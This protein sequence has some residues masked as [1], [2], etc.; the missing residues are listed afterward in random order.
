LVFNF[1]FQS[2]FCVCCFIRFDPYYFF[3][4]FFFNLTLKLKLFCCP[5]IY[6]FFYFHAYSFN[7]HFF[8]FRSFFLK[9]LQF[10]P[11]TSH[12][13]RIG[14][15]VFLMYGALSLITEVMSLKSQCESKK[16]FAYLIFLISSFNF[17]FFRLTS[18]FFSKKIYH[19]ITISWP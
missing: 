1:I 10:Y 17:S 15:R 2:K 8:Y 18:W 11:L 7:Y 19:V 4:Y 6:L 3:C 14:L 9:K 5:L 13:L 12:L 16:N